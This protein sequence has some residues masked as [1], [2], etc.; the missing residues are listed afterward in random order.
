MIC[1]FE[2]ILHTNTSQKRNIDLLHTA[3]GRYYTFPCKLS[4]QRDSYTRNYF[5]ISYV[6]VAFSVVN[7]VEAITARIARVLAGIWI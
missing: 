4:P 3:K 1:H 2:S 5:T 6:Y 7:G